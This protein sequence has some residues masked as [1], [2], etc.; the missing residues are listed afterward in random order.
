[1]S[2]DIEEVLARLEYQAGHA[3]VWRDAVCNWFL[4]TS[5]IPDA[6]GRVGHF[7][8]ASKPRP[9]PLDSYN[10]DRR[11]ALGGGFRRQCGANA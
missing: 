10:A 9:C 8:N 11:H 1:M 2:S 4:R 5:G 6:Q 7:R 3:Q